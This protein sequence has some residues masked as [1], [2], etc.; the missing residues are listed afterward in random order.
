MGT[1]IFKIDEE[2]TD[3]M[4]PEVANPPSKNGQNSSLSINID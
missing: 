3:K 2:I 1:D 4:K